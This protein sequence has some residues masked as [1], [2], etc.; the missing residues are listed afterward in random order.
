MI[1][2][3]LTEYG[4]PWLFNRGLYSVKLKMLRFLPFTESLFDREVNISRL[5]I[6]TPN[7]VNLENFLSSL[8]DEKKIN[9]ISIADNAIEG[10]IKGFSSIEMD[11]GQPIN[12]H[13]NPITGKTVDSNK[14][15]FN[16]PD[17]DSVIGDIK[18][19]WEISRFSHLFYFIRAYMLTK[20]KKYYIAFSN[21]IKDWIK[22]NEY[23]Y[24][25]NFKCGQEAT[26]RMINVLITYESFKYYNLTSV[27]D[28]KNVKKI[29][30]TSYK[31]VLSNFFYAHKC[32]KNNHTLSEITGLI[33]GAWCSNDHK[34]LKK[35]YRLLNKEID[36][37]F[38]D[39]GGYVQYSFNYQRFAFQIIEFA[40]SITDKTGYDIEI[41]N[42]DKLKKS[43]LQLYQLQDE[44]GILPNYG[45]N[46]G[47]LIFPLHTCDY[48]NYKPT[49]NSLHVQLTDNRLYEYGDYDEELLWFNCTDRDSLPIESIKRQDIKFS[50]SGLYSLRSNNSHMMIILQ[51]F[52]NRPAQMDQLHIDLW[53]KGINVSC[54]SG[55]YSYASKLGKSLSLTNAHN[56]VKINGV[57]QMNKHGHFMIYDWSSALDAE[58]KEDYFEGKM[59]SKN[60]YSHKRVVSY[61]DNEFIVKD[62]V[63]SK[64]NYVINFHTPCEIKR[65]NFGLDLIYE[66]NVV[67]KIITNEDLD[68]KKCSISRYYLKEEKINCISIKKGRLETSE[69]RILLKA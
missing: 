51:N 68:I 30:E 36:N 48:L 13:L 43:V 62:S 49:L 67:A 22:N 19:V 33:I 56:T 17:F 32:I 57:E 50:D 35:A 9:I 37:Q 27:D 28:E 58:F 59:K 2:S 52:K 8:S 12:W 60:G 34:K 1:K 63:E 40:L 18:G 47:A 26:L 6:F 66:N 5:D 38:F 65:Q 61:K 45:S 14:K 21:Q 41:Q 54:D 10:K 11:Y 55:T 29:V 69:I 23:S 44:S 16:I 7:I 31:K 4:L 25:P 24:G 42:K 20:D 64:E 3:I 15:W 46:D 53:H 39:D